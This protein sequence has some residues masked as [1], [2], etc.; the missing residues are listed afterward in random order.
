ML[1]PL[2]LMLN[3]KIARLMPVNDAHT[4]WKG[5]SGHEYQIATQIGRQHVFTLQMQR[6]DPKAVGHNGATVAD[7]LEILI[8]HTADNQA[9]QTALVKALVQVTKE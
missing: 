2:L 5:D 3:T 8:E 6:G 4:L 1:P 7:L 9:V